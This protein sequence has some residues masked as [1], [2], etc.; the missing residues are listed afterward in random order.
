VMF[1]EESAGRE[2]HEHNG[3]K[4]GNADAIHRPSGV[5]RVVGITATV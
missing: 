5:M 1:D 3:G 2:W 4:H